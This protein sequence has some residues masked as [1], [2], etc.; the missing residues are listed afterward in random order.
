VKKMK[1]NK[2]FTSL[3][4]VVFALF[5]TV[6]SAFAVTVNW[7]GNGTVNGYCETMWDVNDPDLQ[8]QPPYSLDPGKQLWQFNLSRADNPAY[9]NYSFEGGPSDSDVE[10]HVNNN[11]Q[12]KWFIE[13]NYSTHP[14]A[15]LNS[16][17]AYE[18]Q[19]NSVLTISHCWYN[20]PVEELG[21]WCSP[22]YWRQEHHYGNWP[23]NI[24]KDTKYVSTVGPE[25]D[26]TYKVNKSIKETLPEGDPTIWQVLQYPQVYGAYA[27]NMVGDFLSTAHSGVTFSGDRVEDSCPLGRAEIAD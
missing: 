13:A 4:L 7:S 9:L 21:Q 11:K 18:G 12:A 14:G 16:A 27:F 23:A 24:T 22:G 20:P 8:E 10:S 25:S 19:S 17:S 26:L 2:L 1:I 3:V 5:Q 15:K 6:N